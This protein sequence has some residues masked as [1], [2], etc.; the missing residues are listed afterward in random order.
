[1]KI[2]LLLFFI[3]YS[4][5]S[6]GQRAGDE[7]LEMIEVH[8]AEFFIEKDELP[9]GYGN[10]FIAIKGEPSS[11]AILFTPGESV[12]GDGV[13]WKYQWSVNGVWSTLG[14]P[15][16]DSTNFTFPITK[17]GFYKVEAFKDAEHGVETVS[18]TF[19]VF[20]AK[21]NESEMIVEILDKDNCNYFKLELKGYESVTDDGFYGREDVKYA[22]NDGTWLDV[23]DDALVIISREATSKDEECKISVMDGCGFVWT[24][25]KSAS[26]ESVIPEAKPTIT[27][28][29]TVGVEGEVGDEMGQAPLEVEFNTDEC[30]NA[31]TFEWFLYKDTS[32]MV[33]I[34]TDLLDSLIHEE[35]R[36]EEYFTYIYENTGRYMVKLVATNTNGKN[37]CTD[38]S[39]IK[40]VNV[41]ESLV[42]V[43]NVFTPN[44]DGK[45]DVFMALALSVES[46][47]GIILNRW[48]RKVYEWSDPTGGWDGRINGRLANPGTYYYIITARGREKINTPKYV[49]KGALML[50]R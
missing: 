18:Q 43:P 49:K 25:P 6:W 8:A 40:Y 20:F 48:G 21:V 11:D 1:M 39:E 47:Q 4:V 13:G 38:T 27:L 26:Y 15:N 19:R 28:L 50:I 22:V 44:G 45:N 29:N 10:A 12:L 31:H 30:V 3:G 9:P 5:A 46:F 36:T 2:L 42:E 32:T 35:V 41:V 33:N 34:G 23:H 7:K 17:N 14:A 24:T 37:Q 16:E